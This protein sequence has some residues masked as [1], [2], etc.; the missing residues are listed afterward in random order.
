MFTG[1]VEAK[2]VLVRRIDRGREARLVLR[3]D[4]VD[5]AGGARE[6]IVL[7]ESIAID[8]CCLT[9]DVIVEPG[10]G[11]GKDTVFEV[12]ASSETVGK[13]VRAAQLMKTPYVLVIGDKEVAS[14]ALTVRD[15]QGTETK[16]VPVDDVIAALAEEVRTRRLTQS[17]WG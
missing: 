9:V 2:G 8:G 1:L 5:A 3:G 7:G 17:R 16:G 12:D 6:P 4:L 14:E 15:R 11:S 10:G 13:K